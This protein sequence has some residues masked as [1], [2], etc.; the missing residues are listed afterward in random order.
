MKALLRTH[1]LAVLF[2]IFLLITTSYKLITH[3]TPFYDWDEPLYVQGGIEMIRNNYYLFPMWQGQVWMDKPPVSS[4][5]YGLVAQLP[6]ERELS[7]RFLALFTSI[8]VLALAYV[9]YWRVTKNPFVSLIPIVA[10]AYAPIFVQRSQVV[11]LDVFLLLGWFGYL[12]FR[13]QRVWATLFLFLSTQS[14]SLLGFYPL[15]IMVL[16]FLFEYATK[17]IKWAELIHELRIIIIQGLVLSLWYFIAF[18]WYGETFWQAHIVESHFRRVTAS[19]ESH[20]GERIFYITLL[21]DQMP[22]MVIPAIAGLLLLLWQFYKGTISHETFLLAVAF[23]PWFIFLNLTKT[24]IAWYLYPVIPQFFF[25]ASYPLTV[26]AKF[27]KTTL[28]FSLAVVAYLLF[29]GV[30][31]HAFFT[32]YYS[33]EEEHH[34]VAREAKNT[35]ESLAVLVSETTRT[36]YQ[37]LDAMGLV[38]ATTDW[39]GDHPSMVY[40][41]EKPIG[42]FYTTDSF[43]KKLTNYACA[44]VSPDDVSYLRTAKTKILRTFPS[45]RLYT[46][47]P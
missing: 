6:I 17:K 13:R 36:T 8:G 12:V 19:I 15:A 45:T 39:W 23:V 26:L 1:F 38:I 10:T 9:L 42:F 3:P 25:L 27:K 35:C 29:N 33:S 46:V 7:T 47:L 22:V 37:T 30:I 28:I 31:Q 43:Q 24:K 4:L 2:G 11:S 32:T 40:Y 16:F 41:F 5:L 34:E 14:K 44:S 21:R 20:F 18:A